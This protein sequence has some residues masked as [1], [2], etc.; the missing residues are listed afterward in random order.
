MGTSKHY[1][2]TFGQIL[3]YNFL[4]IGGLLIQNQ[5]KYPNQNPNHLNR[6]SYWQRLIV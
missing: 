4:A 2:T 6:F 3:A 1:L 5:K